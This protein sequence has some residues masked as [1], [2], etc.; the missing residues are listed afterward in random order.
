MPSPS[1]SSSSSI[2]AWQHCHNASQQRKWT[3][4][5]TPVTAVPLADCGDRAIILLLARLGHRAGDLGQLRLADIE[6]DNGTL[7]VMGKGRFEVGLPLPQ[8]EK[9]QVG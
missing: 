1:R 9:L 8:A 7:R 6:W 3:A 4:S 5:S 2:G